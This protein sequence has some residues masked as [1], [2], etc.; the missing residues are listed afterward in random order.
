MAFSFSLIPQN[1]RTPIFY[2][3]VD[4][5]QAGLSIFSQRALLIGQ[6][7][8]AG[9]AAAGVPVLCSTVN[10][11]RELAGPGSMLASMMAA[12]RASDAN[13]EV[14]LLPIEDNAAGTEAVYTATLTGPATASGTLTLYLAGRRV[15]V[16]VTSGDS[17]DTVAAN[18]RAA[19]DAL[20]DFPFVATVLAAVVTVTAR[21]KGDEAGQ[22]DMR[23][24]YR[25]LAGGEFLPAGLGITFA[26]PTPGATNPDIAP[27]LAALGD[28]LFDFIAQP[29]TDSGSLDAFAGAMNDTGGRW[30]YNRRVWGHGFSARSGT[31]GQLSAFGTPRNDQHISILGING[32]LDPTYLWTASAMAAAAVAIKADPA[33]PLQTLAIEGILAPVQAD[34]FTQSEREILLNDGVATFYVDASGVVRIERMITTYQRNAFGQPDTAFLD[35]QTPYTLMTL[36]RELEGFVTR[37]YPRHKLAK[38]GTA[39]GAG[40]AAITPRLFKAELVTLYAEWETRGLVESREAFIENTRVEINAQDPNRLD[41]LW[42]PDLINQLRVVA[43]LAQFRLEFRD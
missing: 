34:R 25:G 4:P 29:Y 33:R 24:N 14:W 5:S 2:L 7:L 19:I 16:G 41:V 8:L 32:N 3:E 35:I 9:S 42:T 31:L 26:N 43:V 17:A 20:V 1:V 39:L 15:Q 40:Q 36:F 21:H 30:S 22:L 13:G 10:Q 37:R 38:N 27:G 6:K 28:E 18:L 12:Y 11:A 23:V